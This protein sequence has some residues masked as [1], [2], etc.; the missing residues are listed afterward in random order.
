MSPNKQAPHTHKLICMSKGTQEAH[1][2]IS[3]A[4][5]ENVPQKL[6]GINPSQ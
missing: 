2:K 5:Q 3:Q 6:H 1:S 4:S